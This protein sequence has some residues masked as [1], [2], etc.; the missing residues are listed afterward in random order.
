MQ[1]R[2][3]QADRVG[4]LL[5]PMRLLLPLVLLRLLAYQVLSQQLQIKGMMW[6]L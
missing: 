1:Q 6:R 2:Q 3:Q 5:L 4:M